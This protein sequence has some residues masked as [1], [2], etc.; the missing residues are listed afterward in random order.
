M[1]EGKINTINTTARYTPP[2]EEKKSNTILWVGTG[3]VLLIVFFVL[4]AIYIKKRISKKAKK[5]TSTNSPIQD[6]LVQHQQ[7]S[8]PESI[9]SK[10]TKSL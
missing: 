1:T 8:R 3:V 10:Q 7:A 2:A 5:D 9:L 6:G 4:L